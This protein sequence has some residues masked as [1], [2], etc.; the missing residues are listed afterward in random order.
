MWKPMTPPLIG[1]RENCLGAFINCL[2]VFETKV[3][4]NRVAIFPLS[5]ARC[6]H[7]SGVSRTCVRVR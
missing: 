5:T 2:A 1:H 4:L 3:V 7:R 6:K